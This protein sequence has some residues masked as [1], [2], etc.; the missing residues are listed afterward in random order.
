MPAAATIGLRAGLPNASADAMPVVATAAATDGDPSA[1]ADAMPAV[2]TVTDSEG[3]PNASAD[4]MPATT[5]SEVVLNALD[6]ST[7]LSVLPS[8][9]TKAMR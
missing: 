2:M 1:S 7:L 8:D 6:T 4:T 3:A 9:H 5:I